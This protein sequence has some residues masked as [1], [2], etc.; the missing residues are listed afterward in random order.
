MRVAILTLSDSGYAGTRE[1]TSGPLIARMVE[2]EG[3]QVVYTQLLPDGIEPLYTTL[4]Q[5][6][7]LSLTT[8]GTGF[9]L[10]DLTPEATAQAIQRPAPGIAEG[11][12]YHSLQITPKAMLSRA[13]AGIRAQTLI[14]NLP[15]SPKAVGECLEYILPPLAHGMEILT[16]QSGNCARSEERT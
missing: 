6:C 14:V 8:G 15:G 7:D 2:Q 3:H 16:G 11:M 13:T 4:C 10:R 9:S 12:R 1:D 5:L